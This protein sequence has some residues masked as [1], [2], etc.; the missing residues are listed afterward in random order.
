MPDTRP[1][2]SSALSWRLG[3]YTTFDRRI[4]IWRLL[5]ERFGG[6]GRTAGACSRPSWLMSALMPSLPTAGAPHLPLA[7]RLSASGLVD[8]VATTTGGFETPPV[9]G[10]R[11]T[12]SHMPASSTVVKSVRL[13]RGLLDQLGIQA[14]T[15]HRTV[16][17]LI[18]MLLAEGLEQRLAGGL[19][20]A[21]AA[22][23]PTALD[24]KD[25]SA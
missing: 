8:R 5:S 18:A 2:R 11:V 19:G 17:N 9:A 20:P 14:A 15:E 12:L 1:S 22:S 4:R 6:R 13:S 10:I 7:T 21:A 23:V 3:G 16:N 25:N 24:S